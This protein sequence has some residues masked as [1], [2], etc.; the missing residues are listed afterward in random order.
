[1]IRL[2]SDFSLLMMSWKGVSP[3]LNGGV[4]GRAS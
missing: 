1:M 3:G 2:V 4:C